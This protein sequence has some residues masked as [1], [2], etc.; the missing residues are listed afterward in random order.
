M[1]LS[2]I[3]TA[4]AG[5]SQ[6]GRFLEV[7]P[8]VSS[9]AI[10]AGITDCCYLQHG[11]HDACPCIHGIN[12]QVSH[13][14][15]AGVAA[16]ATCAA[17]PRMASKPCIKCDTCA[18]QELRR[19]LPAL[20][21]PGMASKPCTKCHTCAQQEL[22]RPPSALHPPRMASKPCTKCHTC[23]Q[24]EL[25]RPLPALHHPALRAG[26][27]TITACI[28]RATTIAQHLL[29]II[30]VGG[31]GDGHHPQPLDAG[32]KGSARHGEGGGGGGA[33]PI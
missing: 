29:I 26:L 10:I 6:V 32:G 15:T 31:G 30:I 7:Y 28:E 33:V 14:C 20:H 19:P 24:Q 23:A 1:V 16:T 5:S 21:L 12:L 4:A 9:F 11:R 2:T 13:L 18:Q 27:K 25:R 8:Q 22:R 3:S 17:P